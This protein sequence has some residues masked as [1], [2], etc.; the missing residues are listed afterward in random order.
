LNNKIS[1]NLLVNKSRL[2]IVS[3]RE[4]VVLDA[5][6]V[7][8]D[9]SMNRI[10]YP[11][12]VVARHAADLNGKPAPFSHPKREGSHVSANDFYSKGA[13]DIGAQVMNSRM[14]GDKNMA[15]I[16]I[17]KEVAERST[18]GLSIVQAAN[19]KQPIGVSTGLIPTTIRKE[20]G[21]D[22]FGKE[23]DQ[24]VESFEYDHLALLLNETPA[25]SHCGTEIIYNSE[26]G[27][28]FEVINHD[29]QTSITNEETHMKHE[30]DLSDLSKEQ[31]QSITALTVNELLQA[32]TATAPEITIE[33]AKEVVTNSGLVINSADEGVFVTNEDATIL[34]NHKAD[35]KERRTEMVTHIVANSDYKESMLTNKDEAELL[36]I[37][38]LLTPSNDFSVNSTVT[39]N[40]NESHS[41]TLL[42]GA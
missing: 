15:E 23:Y 34:A 9:S 27:D 11:S 3:G 14:V 32:V 12:K 41:I 10:L 40:A 4:F 24:V 16:W 30:L 26:T 31:R 5:M 21:K 42:E 13:H 17:D 22:S 29:G 20:S 28:S 36:V 33:Q 19:A 35:A 39:T 2:E 8:G 18:Q 7:L 38:G 37:N 1:V 6:A 25:G